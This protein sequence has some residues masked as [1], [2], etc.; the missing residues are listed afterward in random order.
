MAVA[1]KTPKKYPFKRMSSSAGTNFGSCFCGSKLP[2]RVLLVC[3][4]KCAERVARTI[5]EFSKW[6]EDVKYRIQTWY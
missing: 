1:K 5:I 2:S 4:P 6:D 3:S